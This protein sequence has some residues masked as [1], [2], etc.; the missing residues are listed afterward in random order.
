MRADDATLAVVRAWHRAVAR[1]IAGLPSEHA[2]LRTRIL[3]RLIACHAL[4]PHVR[5]HTNTQWATSTHCHGCGWP[6]A[7]V[8]RRRKDGAV[9]CA[10][11]QRRRQRRYKNRAFLIER[12]RAFLAEVDRLVA[13]V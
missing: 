8:M 5:K 10:E 9:I 2:E 7:L 13:G 1:S 12:D 4:A 6:K 3:E 11:C